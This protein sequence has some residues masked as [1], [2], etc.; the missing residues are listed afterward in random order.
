MNHV[1]NARKDGLARFF[2]SFF[3]EADIFGFGFPHRRFYEAAPIWRRTKFSP[4][5]FVESSSP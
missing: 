4:K 3:D 2:P 1:P 5:A